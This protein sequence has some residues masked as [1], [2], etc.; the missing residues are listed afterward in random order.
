MKKFITSAILLCF[1]FS[2]CGCTQ[3]IHKGSMEQSDHVTVCDTQ[4][5]SLTLFL[6]C[7]TYAVQQGTPEASFVC[8]NRSFSNMID[9]CKEKYKVIH[10]WE[11]RLWIISDGTI[12]TVR[13]D[14]VESGQLQSYY[15]YSLLVNQIELWDD[16]VGK[17]VPVPFLR[18]I[19][20]NSVNPAAEIIPL[21]DI[22][23]DF[24]DRLTT[25]YA[26]FPDVAYNDHIAVLG[27]I[28]LRFSNETAQVEISN[29]T[30]S[31]EECYRRRYNIEACQI[32]LEGGIDTMADDYK[33]E[34]IKITD[35]TTQLLQ[36][37]NNQQNPTVTVDEVTVSDGMI[38]KITYGWER[39]AEVSSVDILNATP[40]LV[41][42]TDNR[43][44]AIYHIKYTQYFI[45]K[46]DRTKWNSNETIPWEY[47][48]GSARNLQPFVQSF[49]YEKQENTWVI[50]E[51]YDEDEPLTERSIAR[52]QEA[53][54]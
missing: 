24:D 36:V 32:A 20:S 49:V 15:T 10:E 2:L 8:I 43:A 19:R 13:L 50:K 34:V 27:S 5:H 25:F 21:Y 17:I 54:A 38:E 3:H 30:L 14:E 11:D 52:L 7:D 4:G 51:V 44:V 53:I 16:T 35:K 28:S 45:P 1:L 42:Y 6:D 22:P 33:A 31:A 39:E 29:T 46:E 26:E 47:L 37:V 18:E 12:F 23:A 9:F 48:S 41:L 40:L